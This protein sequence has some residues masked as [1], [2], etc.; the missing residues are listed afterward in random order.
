MA[1]YFKS[2]S[3]T[4]TFDTR[5]LKKRTSD[6]RALKNLTSHN[7]RDCRNPLLYQVAGGNPGFL[8]NESSFQLRRQCDNICLRSIFQPEGPQ[9]VFFC[10]G[11]YLGDYLGDSTVPCE[12]VWVLVNGWL[13]EMVHLGLIIWCITPAELITVKLE[14]SAQYTWV[15][16]LL[17]TTQNT[18]AG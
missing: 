13:L 12:K 14:E 18:S 8:S 11:S 9:N 4:G 10:A 5:A 6:I 2:W 3:I 16:V 15:Q 7:Q 1:F 17:D